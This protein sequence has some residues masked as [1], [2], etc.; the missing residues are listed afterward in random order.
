MKKFGAFHRLGAKSRLAADCETSVISRSC[1]WWS[2]ELQMRMTEM[3]DDL[4]KEKD[5]LG[6]RVIVHVKKAK[7]TPYLKRNSQEEGASR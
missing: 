4:A 5:F 3:H 1:Q 2:W 7:Q 6:Q